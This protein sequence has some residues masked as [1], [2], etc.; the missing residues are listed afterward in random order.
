M[1]VSGETFDG[2]RWDSEH[3]VRVQFAGVAFC[4]VFAEDL[5]RRDFANVFV[6][7]RVHDVTLK[8]L[9]CSTG[10]L[11]HTVRPPDIFTFMERDF[12]VARFVSFRFHDGI[13]YHLKHICAVLKG[14]NEKM[15]C[16]G[17]D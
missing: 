3:V 16:T 14:L 9:Q 13:L 2:F 5:Y 6:R 11:G 8:H 12:V 10:F 15:L 7:V 4:R 17:G 1:A